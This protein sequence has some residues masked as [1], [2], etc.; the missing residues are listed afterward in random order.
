MM[1][2]SIRFLGI[3]FTGLCLA[4]SGAWCTKQDSGSWLQTVEGAIQPLEDDAALAMQN[5]MMNSSA[6]RSGTS[7]KMKI[8]TGKKSK[9]KST[10]KKTSK[11]KSSSSGKKKSK[12]TSK[13]GPSRRKKSK[14]AA[15]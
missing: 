13:S 12:K 14:S 10:T 1:R 7:K 8:S 2:K 15:Q 4:T 11:S 5:P 3:T 6:G 9:T